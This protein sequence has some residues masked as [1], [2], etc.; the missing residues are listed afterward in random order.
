MDDW[1][2]EELDNYLDDDYLVFDCPEFIYPCRWPTDPPQV[3]I[4]CAAYLAPLV[5]FVGKY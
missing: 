5:R 1:L 2:T 4:D 3:A